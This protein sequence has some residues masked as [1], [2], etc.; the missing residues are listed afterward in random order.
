M[1][2]LA[3]KYKTIFLG[4]PSQTLLKLSPRSS[5]PEVFLGKGVLKI[6][7]KFTGE[8]SWRSAISVKLLCKFIEIAL[9]HECSPVNLLYSFRTPF[10]KDTSG[11]LLPFLQILEF[12]INLFWSLS[13]AYSESSEPRNIGSTLEIA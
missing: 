10:P 7:I 2:N 12:P 11:R 8:H 6:Y 5:R 13:K 4:K 3:N 1:E 9:W